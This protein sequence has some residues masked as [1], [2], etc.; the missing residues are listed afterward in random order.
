MAAKKKIVM[1]MNFYGQL[2]ADIFPRNQQ[3]P[4]F[5]IYQKTNASFTSR[6]MC[7]RS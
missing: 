2:V 3:G 4:I 7:L 5:L 1:Q 6:S